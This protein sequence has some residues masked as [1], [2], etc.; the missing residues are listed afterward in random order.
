MNQLV[1]TKLLKV[2][3]HYRSESMT[4]NERRIM[5]NELKRLAKQ[6]QSEFSH[7]YACWA[8]N[9]N[10][11]SKMKKLNRKLAKKRLRRLLNG[12]LDD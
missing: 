8:N 9:H 4:I 11:W 6:D 5:R 7:K 3:F 12:E 2:K 1:W 10:G